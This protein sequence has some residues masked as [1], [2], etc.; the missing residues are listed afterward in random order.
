MDEIQGSVIPGFDKD[1]VQ[2][3][4]LGID[5]LGPA[6]R[7]IDQ[8]SKKIATAQQVWHFKR[9]F[10]LAKQRG[11]KNAVKSTWIN[12][13]FSYGGLRQL[14][15]AD[16]D[17]FADDAFR[18]RNERAKAGTVGGEETDPDII[19]I[20]A[21]DKAHEVADEANRIKD[22]IRAPGPTAGGV[23]VMFEKYGAASGGMRGREHFGWRDGISQPGVRGWLSEERRALFTPR[24]DY[25]ARPNQGLPGQDVLWPGEFIFGY[26][27]QDRNNVTAAGPDSLMPNG[28]PVAPEWARN[29]SYLVFRELR[30]DVG[31]FHRFL[32]S[33]GERLGVDPEALGARLVGRWPSGAPLV[34]TPVRDKPRL[35]RNNDKNNDFDYGPHEDGDQEG[36]AVARDPDGLRCPFSAHIRKAYPRDETVTAGEPNPYAPLHRTLNE[37]D[38]Q[39]HRMLRRGIPYGKPSKSTPLHPVDDGIDRGLLFMA[40]MT[41]ISGQFEFVMQYMLGDPGFKRPETGV[42]PILGEVEGQRSDITTVLPDEQARSKIGLGRWVTTAGGGYFFAPSLSGLGQLAT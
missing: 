36:A 40:Y 23:H 19:L 34:R 35:G 10:K 30:Q 25:Y 9:Q 3:L 27:R 5:R 29:G 1:H 15:P 18:R 39:T 17:K 41:S 37:G 26:A 28:R 24:T 11:Q 32:F 16:A 33:E 4:F 2:L 31:A 14:V 42:D 12:I 21:G 6:K 22:A 8:I 7:W 20:I 13:A 38:T